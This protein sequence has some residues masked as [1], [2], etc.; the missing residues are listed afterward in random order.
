MAAG[1]LGPFNLRVNKPGQEETD[2]HRWLD[3]K[4]DHPNKELTY[5]ITPQK[6]KFE[7]W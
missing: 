1:L 2:Y 7:P 6:A 3:F 4:A 5:P